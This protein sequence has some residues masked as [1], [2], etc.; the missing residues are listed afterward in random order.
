MS[1]RSEDKG[2]GGISRRSFLQGMGLAAGTVALPL[3]LPLA[4][5]DEAKAGAT[6]PGPVK[7]SLKIN[8]QMKSVEVEPRMTLLDTLRDKLDLTGSKKVCDRGACGGCTVS[9]DGE[10]VCSCMML[11]IDAQGKEITTIEGLAK[12]DG[13]L[14]RVQEG[15][16]EHDA[17]QCGFCTPGFV[18]RAHAFL[19]ENPKPTLDQ[20]KAGLSGN[21]CR[22]GTYTNVFSAVMSAAQK[23]A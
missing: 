21:I 11:A 13:T 14:D 5:A 6:G 20:L 18:M 22:C 4:G 16:I 23:E 12:P 2:G 17:Q 9:L 15:F 19:K 10:S 7:L 3:G 1:T 8:G